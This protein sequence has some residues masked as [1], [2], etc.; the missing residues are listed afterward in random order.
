M[1]PSA[2]F[3]TT[4]CTTAGRPRPSLHACLRSRP[5]LTTL[6]TAYTDTRAADLAW[7][8]GREPLPALAVLD[9]ELAGAELAVAAA[10]RLPPGAPGG[11]GR[12][13]AR[14]RSPACPAAAR[15]CRSASPSGSGDWE[16]EFAAR[17]ETLSRGLV[18][19]AGPGAARAGRRPSARPRRA[20]SPAARTPSPRCSRSGTRA[21]CGGGPGTRT[22]RRGSWWPPGPGSGGAAMPDAASGAARR[23]EC[24]RRHAG[25]PMM[26]VYG[27]AVQSVAPLWVT[28][29][30]VD[31]DVAFAS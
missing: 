26:R 7:A 6:Q 28:G 24:A 25:V 15:R 1:D 20:P 27:L 18:R 19:G 10:R 21:R 23:P 12:Y 14:R 11:G 3:P 17:V 5:M 8:L 13:A 31:R 4:Q 9:L 2:A 29:V 16:Y 30:R 22:R